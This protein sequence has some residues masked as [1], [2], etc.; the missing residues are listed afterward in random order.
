MGSTNLRSLSIAV[1]DDDVEAVAALVSGLR[2]RGNAVTHHVR[3]AD[4]VRALSAPPD[5]LITEACLVEASAL[6]LVRCA[7]GLARPPIVVAMS[8]RA[9]RACVARLVQEGADAYVEKPVDAAGIE[10]ILADSI[11]SELLCRRMAR[12]LVGRLGLKA[13]ISTLRGTMNTEALRRTGSSRRAAARVLEV[14]RRYVQRMVEEYGDPA[15][16]ESDDDAGAS[17]ERAV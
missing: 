4:A 5:V 11:D 15:S 13:A 6:E 14:D 17:L 2:N 1:V 16:D 7:R 9:D 8:A 3:I 10:R 12:L